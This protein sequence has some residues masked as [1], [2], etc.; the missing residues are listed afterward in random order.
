M[1]VVRF[2]HPVDLP[3]FATFGLPVQSAPI[4]LPAEPIRR[5][6]GAYVDELK[7]RLTGVEWTPPA[8][9]D[10]ITERTRQADKRLQDELQRVS[11]ILAALDRACAGE[12]GVELGDNV[13]PWW[14]CSQVILGKG[15]AHIGCP[16]CGQ[17]YPPS[18]SEVQQWSTPEGAVFGRRVTCPADHNLYVC[19][20]G[21]YEPRGPCCVAWEPSSIRTLVRPAVSDGALVTNLFWWR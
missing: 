17:G 1:L 3:E 11:R 21:E 16:A 9:M 12:V 5:L 18:Q 7:R 8:G 2:I 4:T 15:F 19:A 10:W 20:E 13:H 6:Y 14:F